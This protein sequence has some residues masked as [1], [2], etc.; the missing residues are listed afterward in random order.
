MHTLVVRSLILTTAVTAM[1]IN[2]SKKK[3][4]KRIYLR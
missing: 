3:S 2:T 4:E 1:L